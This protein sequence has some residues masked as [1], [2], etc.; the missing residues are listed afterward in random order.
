M[1][2]P[3][4]GVL[5]VGARVRFEGLI[6]TVVGLSGTLVRLA[7]HDGR[8]S[9]IQ[10]AHLLG[11]DGFEIVGG[12]GRVP[13]AAGLLNGVPAEAVQDA[14]QWEQHI[15]EVLTGI[16]PDGPAQAP[17]KAEY[18]PATR[19]LAQR[20]AAKADE[21]GELGFEQVSARTVKRKRSD[22]KL[23]GL[24]AWSIG[25][26]TP[27]GLSTAAQMSGWSTHYRRRSRR[28]SISR[29][30]R[31]ATTCGEPGRSSLMSTDLKW[32]R[33][34]VARRSIGFSTG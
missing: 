34:Q 33:C 4:P 25:G 22:T 30:E 16:P 23:K 2:S 24:L 27:G 9:A 3:R 20:E 28:T 29:R 11:H 12:A 21:L 5:R 26:R 17:A 32:S 7:D 1:K 6:Q 14:L 18:D 19:S 15:V 10:L 13:L 8:T 31:P